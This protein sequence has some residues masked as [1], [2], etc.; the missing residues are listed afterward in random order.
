MDSFHQKHHTRRLSVIVKI[1][2]P[3]ECSYLVCMNMKRLVRDSPGRNVT[4]HQVIFVIGCTW[5]NN[6]PIL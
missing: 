6:F 3:T 1:F 5:L 4:K 2:A